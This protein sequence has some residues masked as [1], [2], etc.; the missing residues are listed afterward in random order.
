MVIFRLDVN[1]IKLDHTLTNVIGCE[2]IELIRGVRSGRKSW[3][4]MC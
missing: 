3:K 2:K 4:V 1:W